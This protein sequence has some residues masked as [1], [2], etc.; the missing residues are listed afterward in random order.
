LPDTSPP[1][2]NPL[3][4]L[5]DGVYE[6]VQG[7]LWLGYIEETFEL[8]GH[9]FTLRTLK[10]SEELEAAL[11][12]KEYLDSIG[13]IKANA[14]SQVAASL[15][16]VDGDP[17]FCPP[18]GPDKRGHIRG[19]FKYMCDNWYPPVGNFLFDRYLLLLQR[20]MAAIEE[21]ENLST[22]SLSTSWPSSDFSKQAG[23]SEENLTIS[24]EPATPT[25]SE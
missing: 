8:A 9:S 18:L 6:A 16:A 11:I 24:N 12:A 14:W 19:K 7:L 21:V 1:L 4:D 13:Q 25:S 10:M 22:R 2:D 15:V 23:P 20:Q 5:P 3:Q 17:N